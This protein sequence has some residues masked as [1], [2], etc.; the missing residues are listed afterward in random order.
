M[1]SVKQQ[2]SQL[3]QKV[4]DQIKESERRL[5]E[6]HKQKEYEHSLKKEYDQQ[7]D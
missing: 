2:E 3:K 5:Q 7:K 4:L 6:M 1:D